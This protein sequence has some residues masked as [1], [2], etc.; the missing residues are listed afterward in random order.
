MGVMYDFFNY[1]SKQNIQPSVPVNEDLDYPTKKEIEASIKSFNIMPNLTDVTSA[2][3]VIRLG[4][5]GKP[6][7]HYKDTA[8]GV[9]KDCGFTSFLDKVG[10]KE[11]IRTLGIWNVEKPEYDTVIFWREFYG[12]SGKKEYEELEVKVDFRPEIK[13]VLK[14]Y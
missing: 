5:Y 11:L 12:N 10:D 4:L 8:S 7:F 9:N 1:L 2:G 3:W 14:N 6:R 13:Q